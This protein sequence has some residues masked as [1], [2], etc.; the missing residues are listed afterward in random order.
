MSTSNPFG[1]EKV[2]LKGKKLSVVEKAFLGNLVAHGMKTIVQ[3]AQFYNLNISTVGRYSK[4]VRASVD[5]HFR[6]GRPSQLDS[7]S[8]DILRQFSTGPRSSTF[9]KDLKEKIKEEYINTQKRR[10]K[11]RSETFAAKDI[12][13]R[14]F[15]RHVKYY[16]S[17]VS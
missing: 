3:V 16:K 4:S 10:F 13:I 12:P 6:H 11:H 14:T 2:D 9:L 7:T 17:Q 1:S 5:M 15:L 8:D